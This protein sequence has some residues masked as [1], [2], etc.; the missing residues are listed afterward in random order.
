LGTI[1][2][3]AFFLVAGGVGVYKATVV[4]RKQH[5]EDGHEKAFTENIM[6]SVLRHKRKSRRH[7]LGRHG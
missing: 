3:H 4:I 5:K 7:L 1:E 6:R 2:A